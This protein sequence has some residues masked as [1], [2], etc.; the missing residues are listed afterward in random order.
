MQVYILVRYK[1]TGTV[2]EAFILEVFKDEETANKVRELL[3]H[4]DKSSSYWLEN[5]SI[6]G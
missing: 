6:L 1:Q 3:S 2:D 5:K 4:S